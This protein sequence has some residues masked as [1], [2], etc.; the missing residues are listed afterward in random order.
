MGVKV[1]DDGGLHVL[2]AQQPSSDQSDPLR[3]PDEPDLGVLGNVG[4]QLLLEV[5]HGAGVVHQDDLVNQM[6]R[7][8]VQD[9]VD[10]AEEDRPGLVVEADDDTGGW[11]VVA[12]PPLR[13]T[14]VV[15]VTR[16]VSSQPQ[17]G[18]LS[19]TSGQVTSCARRSC[20]TRTD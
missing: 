18:L 19:L 4:L 7:R 14:P 16:A 2:G 1:G 5:R 11:Q 15:P 12:V 3:G 10:G 20:R 6:G 17:F 8:P 9:G 13:L